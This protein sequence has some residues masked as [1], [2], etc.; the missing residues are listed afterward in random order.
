MKRIIALCISLIIIFSLAGCQKSNDRLTV[1][2]LKEN[3][4]PDIHTSFLVTIE[5]E[6]NYDNVTT[7]SQMLCFDEWSKTDKKQDET[8]RLTIEVSEEYEIRIYD[9]YIHVYDGYALI[10]QSDSAYYAISDKMDEKIN[11]YLY[12]FYNKPQDT[13]LQYW[14]TEDVSSADFS[15]YMANNAVPWATLYYSDGYS[16]ENSEYVAYT[17]SAYPDYADQGSFITG[18]FVTDLNTKII[19][20]LTA[21]SS[22][23][24]WDAALKALRFTKCE[25]SETLDEGTEY[26]EEWQS[27]DG[28]VTVTLVKTK[29]GY[30]WNIDVQVSNR[31]NMYFNED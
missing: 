11:D 30:A 29:N 15:A 25:N 23:S 13:Q 21:A 14:I 7:L 9:T 28:K 27:N 10:G 26:K 19:G 6:S 17:V 2:G 31:N 12:P 5:N 18:I 22:V 16:D 3:F 24:E 1:D 20:N 8:L 4:N